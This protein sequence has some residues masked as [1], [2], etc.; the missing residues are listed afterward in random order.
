MQNVSNLSV[1]GG[2]SFEEFLPSPSQQRLL[3]D[4]VYVG[5]TYLGGG[6]PLAI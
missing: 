4:K 1:F 3:M 5:K 6:S 2:N